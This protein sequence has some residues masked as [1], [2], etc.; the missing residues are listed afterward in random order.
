MQHVTTRRGE[1]AA[2]ALRRSRRFA[3]VRGG[4][5]IDRVVCAHANDGQHP[6]LPRELRG[7]F[8]RELATEAC[9]DEQTAIEYAYDS[10]VG[11]KV[12]Q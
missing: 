7:P 10:V 12:R 3:T 1:T 2:G 11:G 5:G 8:F 4:L 9:A 6:E